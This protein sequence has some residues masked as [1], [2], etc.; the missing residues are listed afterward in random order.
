MSEPG[1]RSITRQVFVNG[2]EGRLRAGWRLLAALVALGVVGFLAILLVG[3]L[4]A[5]A[6][7]VAPMAVGGMLLSALSS[8]ILL[9]VV[10]AGVLVAVAW[11]IDVRTLPDL[12]LGGDRWWA[13]L[14]FGLVLGVVMTTTVFAAEMAAGLI[15]VEQVFV[16]RPGLGIDQ[17]FPVAFALTVLL[18]VAV[19]VG[20]EV[21]FRGYFMTNLA[22]GL[23]G[24]GPVGPR[25]ALAVAAVLTSAIFGVVHITNPNA[26]LVSALNITVVGCFLAWAYVVTEDLGIAIGVHI[27]WNFSLSS[28]Y[29]F[30]VSGLTT[31]ATIIDVRQSGDPLITGGPFGPEAGLVVYLALAVAVALTW[32]WVRRTGHRSWFPIG[33][34]VPDLRTE[35]DAHPDV[36]Q[37]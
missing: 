31:P 7:L 6:S 29:G 22:E 32:W 24:L 10:V 1:G 36:E 33:V 20:E 2:R 18:F 35:S 14:G 26:T 3:V 11:W 23:N 9:N 8:Q 16:S 17:P 15:T 30:P 4:Q 28:V 37:D 13:N 27:T 25:G 34:A 19:G 21:L 5:V 12:G